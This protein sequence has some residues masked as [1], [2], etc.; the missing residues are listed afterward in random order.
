MFGHVRQSL[1]AF[2]WVTFACVYG[3]IYIR[4]VYKSLR[5]L[6]HIQLA[7]SP[8]FFGCYLCCGFRLPRGDPDACTKNRIIYPI[9]RRDMRARY[10]IYIHAYCNVAESRQELSIILVYLYYLMCV[11][12]CTCVCDGRKGET[13]NTTFVIYYKYKYANTF[14]PTENTKNKTRTIKPPTAFY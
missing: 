5:S 7:F 6:T 1:F 3:I 10:Y 8:S 2:T 12:L 9:A 11:C 4:F 13:F 14:K